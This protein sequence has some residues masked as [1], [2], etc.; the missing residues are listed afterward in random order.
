M[1]SLKEIEKLAELS[2]LDLSSE[3]KESFRKDM[4]SILDYVG[5]IQ[6]VSSNISNEKKAGLIRNVLR[7]DSNPHESG[8]YTE[9]LI[10]AAPKREGDY[11]KVKKIL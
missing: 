6:K 11:L 5:Q 3:E 1:I 4:D 2:R 8:I 7:E 10:S 9:T